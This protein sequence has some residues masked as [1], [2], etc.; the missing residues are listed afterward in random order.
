MEGPKSC[1]RIA[2]GTLCKISILWNCT[3]V[4]QNQN[5]HLPRRHWTDGGSSAA[6]CSPMRLVMQVT[7]P[8]ALLH[9]TERE[10]PM[11][12]QSVKL[13]AAEPPPVSPTPHRVSV[14]TPALLLGFWFKPSEHYKAA[15]FLASFTGWGE[16]SKGWGW[17]CSYR[18][19][20]VLSMRVWLEQW[21]IHCL[22]LV[23]VF[24]FV[25]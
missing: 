21:L 13:L 16:K 24:V 8:V 10:L 14:P 19:G 2:W 23:W 7:V 6:R 4:F 5:F 11:D 3:P 18:L 17:R 25:F 15:C 22:K 12:A 20:S 1:T 9:S